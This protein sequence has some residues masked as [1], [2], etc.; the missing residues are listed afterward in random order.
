MRKKYYIIIST[1]M[2]NVAIFAQGISFPGEPTQAPIGSF[3]LLAL[4]G[5]AIAYKKL[6][7]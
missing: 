1:L 4:G 7:K 6:K 2:I 3:G 5:A